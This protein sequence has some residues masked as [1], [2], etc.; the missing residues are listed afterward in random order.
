[1]DDIFEGVTNL[2]VKRDGSRGTH[3]TGVAGLCGGGA[4]SGIN[5]SV[6]DNI[7][8]GVTVLSL[9][10]DGRGSL[11]THPTGFS[12]VAFDEIVGIK[13]V[14]GT[15]DNRDGRAGRGRTACSGVTWLVCV[16]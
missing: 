10:S 14:A 4:L 9:K 12:E 15:A 5:G 3:L 16:G 1:M 2:V 11:G 8:E 6:G 7:L 13:G